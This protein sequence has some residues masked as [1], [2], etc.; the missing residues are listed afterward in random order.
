LNPLDEIESL[1]HVF[2]PVG[3]SENSRHFVAGLFIEKNQV[4]SRN[5]V[6]DFSPR[7]IILTCPDDI[8]LNIICH[9]I[10]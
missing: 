7:K 5:L 1:N 6:F 8:F 10:L 4:S 3:T 2:S 9:K